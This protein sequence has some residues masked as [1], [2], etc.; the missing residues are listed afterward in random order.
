MR[1][2]EY[3]KLDDGEKQRVRYL[4]NQQNDMNRS[5]GIEIWENENDFYQTIAEY[6]IIEKGD[7]L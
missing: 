3:D 6:F 7:E 4:M 2:K 1:E 5:R